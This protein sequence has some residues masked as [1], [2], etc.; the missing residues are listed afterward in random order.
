MKENFTIFVVDDDPLAQELV[1]DLLEPHYWIECFAN[2]ESCQARLESSRPDMF[3]LDVRMPGMDGY[4]FCRQLKDDA[5][6]RSIPV[7]FVSGQDTLDACLKGYDAGGEDFIVK[8]FQH[9][10]LLRKVRV[11]QQLVEQ[12]R[13]MQQQLDDSELLSSLVMANMDEYAVLVRFLREVIGC[14][15]PSMVA[16]CALDML[17]RYGLEAVIQVRGQN[18]PTLTISARGS[19]HPLEESV[20]QHVRTLGRI[21]EFKTR[22][23][24]N[25]EHI[26]ILINN[27]PIHDPELC[28]RLRDH[29]CIAAE[30]A[31]ARLKAIEAE[32]ANKRNESGI[33]VAMGRIQGITSELSQA[34]LE[35]STASSDL[36]MRFENSLA[37]CFINLGLTESQER[38]LGELVTGFTEEMLGLSDRGLESHAPLNEVSRELEA[39]LR[40]PALAN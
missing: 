40:S 19:N 17:K 2:A 15:T 18:N 37:K 12:A 25:F 26:T 22:G 4:D 30:S 11:A 5:S 33:R 8:P 35:E 28:G 38:E 20:V 10:A 32:A 14:E 36:V 29:I 6:L 31:E 9:D 39:L 34:Y 16:D 3:L 13:R 7:T 1:R 27:A 23:V 24:H 21:F